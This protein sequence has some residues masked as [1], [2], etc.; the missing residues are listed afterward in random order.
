M[1][2]SVYI[3]ASLVMV[4]S[5]AITIFTIIGIII[6]LTSDTDRNNIAIIRRVYGFIGPYRM[7][8]VHCSMKY[9]N[10]GHRAWNPISSTLMYG[11]AGSIVQFFISK[12]YEEK[13]TKKQIL[14]HKLI[15]KD[16]GYDR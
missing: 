11:M 7:G 6:L 9:N 12:S 3:L 14:F 8:A 4:T 2:T 16:N 13:L 1:M 15:D 10:L 5:V